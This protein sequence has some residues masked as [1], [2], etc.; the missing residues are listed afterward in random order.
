MVELAEPIDTPPPRWGF[1]EHRRV[2]PTNAFADFKKADTEQS[3][4]ARFEQQ[5]ARYPDRLAVKTS[6]HALAYAELDW[7]ANCVARAI[8][9]QDDRRGAPVALLFDDDTRGVAAVIG[10]LKS[11][12]VSAVLDASQPVAR[13]CSILED[14]QASLI[15]TDNKH[16]ALAQQSVRLRSAAH[17][18]RRD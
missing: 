18:R 9:A 2:G 3:I 11:G 4:P 13:L 16:L 10:A 7:A 8:L 12:S 14:L 6:R 1:V 5:V 15:L 17:Q